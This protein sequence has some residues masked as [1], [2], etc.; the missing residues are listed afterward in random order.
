MQIK[1]STGV[2]SSAKV[3]VLGVPVFKIDNKKKLP[4]S[5]ASLDK[6]TGGSLA[7]VVCAGDFRGNKGESQIIYPAKPGNAKRIL[8]L[9]LGQ[10]DKFDVDGLRA[11]AAHC[12]KGAR[13]KH[14]KKI[15]LIAPSAKR[16][17]V[18]GACQAL[19]EGALL[20]GYRFDTYLT[21]DGKKKAPR[22][23]A[24]LSL[25]YAR[26][27]K[28]AEARTGIKRGIVLAESQNLARD[29]SNAPG[30]LMT[31][32]MLAKAAQ[33]MSREVGLRVKVMEVPE[34]KRRR[35]GGILA[36]GQGSI[37]PPRLV[38]IEHNPRPA[39]KTKQPTICI[40]GKGITFD[41]GGISIKGSA[42]MHEMKHDMSGAATVIG[43]MRVVKLLGLP[44]RVVGIV[45]TA[46][47]LPSATAYRPGDIITMYSG[48]TVEIINTDAEGR[49]VLADAL[50]YA[51]KTYAPVA[52]ID[53][54][55]L[56]GACMV[57]LGDWATGMMGTHQGVIDQLKKSGERTGECAWQLPL[58]EDHKKLMR[59]TVSDLVNAGSRHAGA[60]MAAGFLAAFVKKAPWVHL[61]I[62]GTGWTSRVGA[63]QGRGA[64]GVGVRLLLD[65]LE[66]WKPVS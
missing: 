61:D 40:I 2:P 26:L 6:S 14:A 62:A 52:M 44:H 46:E 23:A 7:L 11:V 64:T 49:L 42:N 18:E 15:A 53:L 57:A 25:L 59:G 50:A 17:S 37:H 28:P 3:D 63:Y 48:K 58:F 51:E 39:S 31:P 13:A 35:M 1:V 34:L 66:H 20:G 30:N 38:V 41:S 55:T 65:F 16:V 29:L 22:P 21:K 24:S 60:S 9:G 47:N 19:A 32:A 27:A 54:A 36:V 10:E 43:L 8:L 12:V 33:K 56:T 4:G 5:L 45:A